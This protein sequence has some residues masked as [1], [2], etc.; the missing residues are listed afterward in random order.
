MD[1]YSAHTLWVYI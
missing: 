1:V